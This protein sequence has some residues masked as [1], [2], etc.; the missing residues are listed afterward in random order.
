MTPADTLRA[1]AAALEAQQYSDAW[2]LL[3]SEARALVP[4]D[5]FEALAR[6]QPE[7]VRDTVTL[8]RASSSP[9]ATARLEL[10]N[11]DAVTLVEE[12]GQWRL[13]PA[14][15]DFY[16]QNTPLQALRSFVRAL[17]RRRY[18]VLVQLAPSQ[19]VA[20]MEQ[21]AREG[22]AGQRRAEDVL[23]ESWEGPEAA[24]VA[25]LVS[26]LE[27]ALERGVAIEVV[28]DRATLRYGPGAASVARLVRED[29][30]WKIEDPE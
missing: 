23:R 20:Q 29:G 30:L 10:A 6:A 5:R 28:G 2:Q 1:Y 17:E 18:E 8:Y 15:L 25:G 19:A 4:Y 12:R 21:L 9:R 22:D 26:R 24:N 14:S 7:S 3:S 16:A 13:D 11:G 27:H